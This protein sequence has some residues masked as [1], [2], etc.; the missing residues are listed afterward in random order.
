MLGQLK[1]PPKGFET[2]V[3]RHFY[4][5]RAEILTDIHKWV[6][7]AEKVEALYTNLVHDHNGNIAK[8]FQKSKTR[9]KEALEKEVKELEELLNKLEKPTNYLPPPKK[10]QSKKTEKKKN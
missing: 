4:I 3:K 10:Q 7:R 1:N 6:E 5:K 8:D 9:Y 2:V